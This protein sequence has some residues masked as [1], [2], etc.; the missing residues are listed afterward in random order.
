MIANH[1]ILCGGSQ[2][3]TRSTLVC[4]ERDCDYYAFVCGRE[5]CN[6]TI[7]HPDHHLILLKGVLEKASKSSPLG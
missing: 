4:K 3:P 1:E 5:G 7:K 2:E 6:C